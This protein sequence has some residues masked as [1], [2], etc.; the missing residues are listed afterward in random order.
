TAHGDRTRRPPSNTNSNT[1]TDSLAAPKDVGTASL[2][3]SNLMPS[4]EAAPE[5]IRAEGRVGEMGPS[6]RGTGVW[7]SFCGSLVLAVAAVGCGDQMPPTAEPGGAKGPSIERAETAATPVA[8]GA[9]GMPGTAPTNG[10]PIPTAPT[11]CQQGATCP[12][13]DST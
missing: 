3:V 13:V 7:L 8:Q 12:V 2:R 9:T 11:A 4:L 1:L 10:V 5:L 6:L